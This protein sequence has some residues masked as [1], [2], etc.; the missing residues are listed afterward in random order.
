MTGL[1]WL[2]LLAEGAA[3]GTSLY[4][5]NLLAIGFTGNLIPTVSFP[6]NILVLNK[7]KFAFNTM[8]NGP[9][10][11]FFINKLNNCSIYLFIIIIFLAISIEDTWTING[12]VKGLPLYS[13]IL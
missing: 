3:I 1:I 8:V 7:F 6:A 10:Q 4:L 9:G 11:K 5:I 2:N 13:N 12:S